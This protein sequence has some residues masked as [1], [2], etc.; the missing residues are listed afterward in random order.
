MAKATLAI[1]ASLLL[2]PAW[3]AVYNGAPGLTA[4]YLTSHTSVKMRDLW[5]ASPSEPDYSVIDQTHVETYVAALPGGVTYEFD[6]EGSVND[7][8]NNRIQW[9]YRT[10]PTTAVSLR[11]TMMGYIRA[12]RPALDIGI[13]G[14][15][16]H[17][18]VRDSLK[19]PGNVGKAE[20]MIQS[21]VE[22]KPMIDTL[23]TVYITAYW[24]WLGDESQYMSE[25]KTEQRTLIAMSELYY[26][27]KPVAYVWH[28]GYLLELG[29]DDEG[30]LDPA[31]FYE[32]LSFFARN[33][34]D[35]VFWA[36]QADTEFPDWVKRALERHNEAT[37]C[38]DP[39]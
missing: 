30:L 17:G 2:T 24:R 27:K 32:M 8:A 9:L 19:D 15:P 33:C 10:N 4:P 13:Y 5:P 3:A 34:V 39:G 35:M 20:D 28:R 29:A 18:M 1:L 12:E 11:A 37:L 22:Y 36:Q 26:G 31:I 38:Y 25:W 14:I 23:D 6:L 7:V 21:M 16:D